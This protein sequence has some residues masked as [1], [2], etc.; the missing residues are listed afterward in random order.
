MG[1]WREGGC[2]KEYILG[3]GQTRLYLTWKIIVL[4]VKVF[5][6]KCD[7]LLLE[8]LHR[9]DTVMSMSPSSQNRGTHLGAAATHLAH[10]HLVSV[11][12]CS[13]TICGEDSCTIAV[14][15]SVNQTDS[16]I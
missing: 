12:A 8:M 9:H 16:V 10:V 15:V 13:G 3:R 1:K 5:K 4:R 2:Q 11:F 6:H 7:V 14:R